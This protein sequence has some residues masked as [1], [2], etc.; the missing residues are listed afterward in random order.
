MVPESINDQPGVGSTLQ[1]RKL[2]S[3][4]RAIAASEAPGPR[5]EAVKVAW[6]AQT[7]C[8]LLIPPT[9]ARR[10]AGW[11]FDVCKASSRPLAMS[12]FLVFWG[13]RT[14][15]AGTSVFWASFLPAHSHMSTWRGKAEGLRWPQSCHAPSRVYQ[16]KVDS[17]GCKTGYPLLTS[18]T[19]NGFLFPSEWG[20]PPPRPQPAYC[21]RARLPRDSKCIVAIW[22]LLNLSV[23]HFPHMWNMDYKAF[24]SLG[25]YKD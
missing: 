17:S 10:H 16:A 3:E 12:T 22:S 15:D 11:T 2:V 21:S 18:R 23:A 20:H 24:T 25:Y 7:T 8:F 1:V 19:C 14:E 6:R 4:Y 5:S 9:R 13:L